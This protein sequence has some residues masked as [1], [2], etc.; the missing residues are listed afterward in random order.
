MEEEVGKYP[1]VEIGKVFH[2]VIKLMLSV[3]ERMEPYL[4]NPSC[5]CSQCF[6]CTTALNP[7]VESGSSSSTLGFGPDRFR[8]GTLVSGHGLVSASVSPDS[9]RQE[10]GS[11]SCCYFLG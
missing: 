8:H 3:F 2:Y 4:K 11:V 1:W 9:T 10:V 7:F 6:W 5:N